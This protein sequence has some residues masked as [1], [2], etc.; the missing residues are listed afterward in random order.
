MEKSCIIWL[1]IPAIFKI[2]LGL[3]IKIRKMKIR[4]IKIRKGGEVT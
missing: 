2:R 4:K 1:S 3:V